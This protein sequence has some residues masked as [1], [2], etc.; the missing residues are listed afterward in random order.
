[1]A[2]PQG[3]NSMSRADST[4]SQTD[5][6]QPYDWRAKVEDFKK[7]MMSLKD[8]WI[9][10]KKFKKLY[11]CMDNIKNWENLMKPE[12]F[13]KTMAVLQ[14]T[15]AILWLIKRFWDT[16]KANKKPR[17]DEKGDDY[18]KRMFWEAQKFRMTDMRTQFEIDL[19]CEKLIRRIRCYGEDEK[20]RL[21]ECYDANDP[22]KMKCMTDLDEYVERFICSAKELSSSVIASSLLENEEDPDE[23]RLAVVGDFTKS[24]RVNDIGEMM[25]R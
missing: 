20:K 15:L 10:S 7:G 6:K 4:K 2:T 25:I 23:R 11:N 9:L 12:T 22:L 24:V 21:M 8:L 17:K 16:N 1:M 13:A 19:Y 14:E 18:V 5:S 3:E